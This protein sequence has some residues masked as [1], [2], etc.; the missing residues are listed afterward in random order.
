MF[1][2]LAQDRDA[3][4]QPEPAA[5]DD[6]DDGSSDGPEDMDRTLSMWQE[7]YF[8]NHFVSWEDWDMNHS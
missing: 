7:V 8:N 2:E 3:D 5:Q 4:D 6:D 1:V